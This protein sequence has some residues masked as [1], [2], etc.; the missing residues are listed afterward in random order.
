L[1]FVVASVEKR[2]VEEVRKNDT[3]IVVGETGSGKTTRKYVSVFP[4]SQL[5]LG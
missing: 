5:L 3:L 2:L 1:L 4:F